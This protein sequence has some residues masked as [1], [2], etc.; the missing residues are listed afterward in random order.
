MA[1]LADQG[2][3]S[4][5]TTLIVPAGQGV[6]TNSPGTLMLGAT[7]ATA[8][9]VGAAGV[10]MSVPGG[11]TGPQSVIKSAAVGA[12]INL[13]A[14]QSG[15]LIINDS[16]S[17]SPAFV[18]PAAAVGLVFDYLC[19][20]TTDACVFT[21][22]DAA[23][24]KGRTGGTSTS[25]GPGAAIVS[26]ATSGNVTHTQASAVAGDNVRFVCDGTNWLMVAQIGIFAAS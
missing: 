15:S 18:L 14:A 11:K 25:T 1:L 9:Q 10:P 12:T 4:L 24:I 5:G 19:T 21:C 13:T 6:D 8:V 16:T 22:A 2:G 20:S 3:P 23:V 17:G 26:T 7:A